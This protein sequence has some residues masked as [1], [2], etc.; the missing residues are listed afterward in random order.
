MK[1]PR[2]LSTW[3]AVLV[4]A[5]TGP[6]WGQDA[7]GAEA[8]RAEQAQAPGAEPGRA[9]ASELTPP[10][11]VP[12]PPPGTPD[13]PSRSKPPPED[14][15]SREPS[16]REE[17]SAPSVSEPARPG[18]AAARAED[19]V[20][21][22][23]VEFVGGTAG[24]IVAG[25][26]GL[27]AGYLL[28]LPTVGCDDCRV[29]SLVGGFTGV[30][31][32]IPAGTWAGGRLMG[33]RGQFIS[34]AGGSLVG[35]GGALLGSLLLNDSGDN[36]AV[37]IALLVLPIVGATAGYELSNTPG[38]DTPPPRASSQ[39]QLRVVPLAGMTEHGPRLGLM[40][41]F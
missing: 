31:I 3:L 37:A 27:V 16:G 41:R 5:G 40:G 34:T 18:R 1:P 39:A 10:P 9:P 15:P 13:R 19:P 11:L 32:G 2:A 25:T 17:T 20:P 28:A 4:L 7:P 23:A 26:M 33:G 36:E 6:A 24:G 21:R 29:V 12:V 35:W 30:L 8:S 22:V 38:L 14:E